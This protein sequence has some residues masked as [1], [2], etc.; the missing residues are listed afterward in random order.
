MWPWEHAA[1]GYLACS[2]FVH[3]FYRRSPSG[4]EALLVVAASLVPDLIDKPLGW[5]FHVFSSGYGVA[6]SV[7]FAAPLA[8][9]VVSLARRYE[10]TSLGV[11]F[12]IGYVSHLPG[13]LLV[14]YL[15]TGDLQ[16]ARVLWP[17]RSVETAY[18]E[19]FTGTLQEYLVEYL[20]AIAAG[21]LSAAALVGL[22]ALGVCLLVWLLDGAPGVREGLAALTPR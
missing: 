18:S 7:F 4:R 19:G 14:S 2:V 6:H 5:E 15:Y 22:G 10:R 12:G 21:E 9:G 16:L 20:R 11:A 1:V 8:V 17:L 13:D 3:L